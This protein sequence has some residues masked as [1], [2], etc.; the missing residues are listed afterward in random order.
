MFST[1]PKKQLSLVRLFI[2]QVIYVHGDFPFFLHFLSFHPPNVKQYIQKCALSRKEFT[3]NFIQFHEFTNDF[4]Q[5]HEF[6]NDFIQFHEFSN[7]FIQFHEFTND[8]IRFQEFYFQFHEFLNE[9]SQFPLSRI[10]LGSLNYH[11]HRF[12]KNFT[13]KLRLVVLI[14]S[15][16]KR[17]NS[18][19]N[20]EDYL[21]SHDVQSR[22]F[23]IK[24]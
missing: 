19:V 24:R 6:S 10:T 8:F 14:N 12:S 1:D 5:F 7:D 4:I 15:Y 11:L 2:V 23:L 13:P 21:L 9:N 18:H 16:K 20:L 17:C 22:K 3:N